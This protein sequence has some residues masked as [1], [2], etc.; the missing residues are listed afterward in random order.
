MVGVTQPAPRFSR[1]PCAHPTPP[2]ADD[3]AQTLTAWGLPPDEVA[4]LQASGAVG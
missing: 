4:R 2:I 1:T 3:P